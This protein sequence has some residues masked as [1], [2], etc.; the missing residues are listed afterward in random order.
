MVLRNM[1]SDT[2]NTR[3]IVSR[4][5]TQTNKRPE[6]DGKPLPKCPVSQRYSQERVIL[7]AADNRLLFAVADLV[8]VWEITDK[9]FAITRLAICAVAAIFC[10]KEETSTHKKPIE[11]I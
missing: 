7:C 4:G 1:H 5:D 10:Q 8:T 3:W 6:K 2:N 11:K 9:S